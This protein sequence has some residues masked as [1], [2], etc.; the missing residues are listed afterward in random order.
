M[1]KKT[2]IVSLVAALLFLLGFPCCNALRLESYKGVSMTVV[3]G[4]AHGE[5]V[6]V[7]I[8]NHT[9]DK[10]EVGNMSSVRL[11]KRTFGFW[12]PLWRDFT[13]CHNT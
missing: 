12:L 3:A 6:T 4:S 8:K 7:E 10:I 1:K 9:D 13:A 5:G 2:I 11:Q